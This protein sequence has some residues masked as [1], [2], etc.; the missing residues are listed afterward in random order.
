MNMKEIKTGE[1]YV[2]NS[3]EKSRPGC[4][5]NYF[6]FFKNKT[7][8]ILKKLNNFKNKNIIQ[9]QGLYHDETESYLVS[10]W[11]SPYDLKLAD[12]D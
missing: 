9:V 5:K 7:V 8:T 12:H 1:E 11:C 4:A 10:F 3:G 6:G 2:L